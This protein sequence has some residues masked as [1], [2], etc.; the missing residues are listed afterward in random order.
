MLHCSDLV[1]DDLELVMGPRRW[2]RATVIPLPSPHLSPHLRGVW[3]LLWEPLSSEGV[4][5]AE[6]LA[7]RGDEGQSLGRRPE[8]VC[9]RGVDPGFGPPPPAWGTVHGARLGS[10]VKWGGVVSG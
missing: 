10:G 9:E 7:W 8:Q 3:G 5:H 1:C 4:S 2:L 6:D